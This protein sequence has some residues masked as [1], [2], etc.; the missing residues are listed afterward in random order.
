[1]NWT[2]RI[3]PTSIR[4][5]LPHGSVEYELSYGSV[6]S[7]KACSSTSTA[8]LIFLLARQE[9]SV[10]DSAVPAASAAPFSV[11]PGADALSRR[12]LS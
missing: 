6:P 8:D 7:T 4:G 9:A 5:D 3:D 2:R 10:C 1:M 12:K 11:S